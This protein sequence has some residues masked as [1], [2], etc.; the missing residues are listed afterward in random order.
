MKK[1]LVSGLLLLL[2]SCATTIKDFNKYQ[3]AP[4]LQAE[5][6]P[7]Q[8]ELTKKLP[9][10]VVLEFQ[11]D[12][13]NAKKISATRF[14]ED[15]VI[16]ILH[17]N[18]L[19]EL[20]DRKNLTKLENEIRLAEISG[21][22]KVS[23]IKSVDFAI[24]GN[25]SNVSFSSEFQ[26]A[27]KDQDGKIITP[28][29]YRYVASVNGSIKVYQLPSLTIVDTISFSGSAYRN[30][31]VKDGGI[32][33]RDFQLTSKEKAKEFDP[34]LAKRAVQNAIN[35]SAY[36]IKS[37]F[38]KTGYIMEKRVLDGQT[39]FLINLGQR[40]GIKQEDKVQIHQKYS[41]Y[42]PLTG[43]TEIA[44]RLVATGTVA[45]K[46]EEGKTWIIVKDGA[47]QIK[48]GDIVKVV[49]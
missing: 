35:N 15:S 25:I 29:S 28:D 12:D 10:V 43:K 40:D 46:T 42:N 5:F 9:S 7:N 44:T 23:N 20:Q 36:K 13:E 27:F 3:K 17:R 38:A 6:M 2:A 30:E 47:A 21:S 31:E 16:D 37:V 32:K 4:L 24:D 49:Y 14:V 18:K 39:I 8:Q 19:V 1:V 41:D 11:T 33:Y 26:S 22:N 48:L 45:D 34:A